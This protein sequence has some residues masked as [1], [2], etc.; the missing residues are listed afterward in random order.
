MEYKLDL[1]YRVNIKKI[2]RLYKLMGLQTLY[3]KPKTTIKDKTNYVYSYLLKNLKINCADQVW[4][5]DITYIPM[6]RG[7][8]YMA[9]I[10]DIHSR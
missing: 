1:G 6:F 7:F 5:T 2:R 8:M 3:V 10:I 9:A 4:Q